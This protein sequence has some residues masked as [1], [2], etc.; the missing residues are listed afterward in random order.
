MDGT[1]VR[2]GSYYFRQVAWGLALSPVRGALGPFATVRLLMSFRRVRER[3]RDAGHVPGLHRRQF[4]LAAERLRLPAETAR[5]VL[6]PLLYE[7]AYEGLDGYVEA[8]ARAALARLK[9]RPLK[10]GVL[11]DY[12][13]QRKLQGMRLADIGWDLLLS[14]ED[15]DALKPNPQVF[16]R[17][18]ELLGVE[19]RRA[20]YVGDR[21]DTDVAGARAAGLRTCLLRGSRHPGPEPDFAV[22]SLTELADRLGC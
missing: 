20:L 13:T 3:L 9:R 11:S 12:P 14:C 16:E 6:M 22:G 4:E 7:S 8:G 17:A 1:L 5:A 2:S 18:L 21:R 19:P 10:L 15:V